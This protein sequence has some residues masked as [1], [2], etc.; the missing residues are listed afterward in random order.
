MPLVTSFEAHYNK[1]LNDSEFIFRIDDFYKLCTYEF[2]FDKKE[3][4]QIKLNCLVRYKDE[5]ER[6]KAIDFGFKPKSKK[7]IISVFSEIF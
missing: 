6:E 2:D 3:K 5:K 7:N 1:L 4:I